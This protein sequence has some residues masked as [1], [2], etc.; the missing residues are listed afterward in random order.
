MLANGQTV[1]LHGFLGH[2]LGQRAV[3]GACFQVA[4]KFL[5]EFTAVFFV[6]CDGAEHL[7]HFLGQAEFG[8]TALLGVDEKF[9]FDFITNLTLKSRVVRDEEMAIMVLRDFQ[10]VGCSVRFSTS[11]L[12]SAEPIRE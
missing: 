5:A 11:N 9:A 10:A 8:G 6:A 2:V 7:E 1:G 3:A 12:P 4:D